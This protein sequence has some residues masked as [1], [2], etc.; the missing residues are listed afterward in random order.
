M[1][2]KELVPGALDGRKWV[3][4]DSPALQ[5]D[6]K[7]AERFDE[8]FPKKTKAFRPSQEEFYIYSH[9]ALR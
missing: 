3:Y 7:E 5:T 6:P 8:T 2:A 9:S 4:Q 1:M